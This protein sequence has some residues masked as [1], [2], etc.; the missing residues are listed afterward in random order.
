MTDISKAAYIAVQ[1]QVRYW[2][3]AIINGEEDERGDKTPFRNGDLW[4]PVIRISD[5]L[6][7]NWPEGMEASF[8]FKVCDTG[9]YFLLADDQQTVVSSI[10]QD[11]VPDGLCHGDRGFGDYI[12]F[13]VGSDGMISD[14]RPDINPDDWKTGVV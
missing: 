7:L 12:I 14:Y 5:G 6:V 1:A 8:H 11:Y 13:N 3:D 4:E 10:L 2:D 9:T